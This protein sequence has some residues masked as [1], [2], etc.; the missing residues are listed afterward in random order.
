MSQRSEP[1]SILLEIVLPE[2][3]QTAYLLDPFIPVLRGFGETFRVT[4]LRPISEPHTV[5]STES[6]II[7]K[8][9]RPVKRQRLDNPLSASGYSCQPA[10]SGKTTHCLPLNGI[11]LEAA[12][13]AAIKD[14]IQQ[15]IHLVRSE[16]IEKCHATRHSEW[17]SDP[18]TLRHSALAQLEWLSYPESKNLMPWFDWAGMTRDSLEVR[19]SKFNSKKLS[20][21]VSEF[22][23]TCLNPS[24]NSVGQVT[25]TDNKF[26]VTLPRRSGFSLATMENFRN[27]V[28]RINHSSG[29]DAVVIDPPWQNKSASRGG[30]YRTVELYDLFKMDL[31]GILGENAGK[32]ALIAIWVTNRPKFRRFL[33]NKFLPD[34]HVMGPYSEWYWVKITASPSKENQPDLLEGGKPIFDLESTSPRRCYEG[35]VLGWYIPPSLRLNPVSN[36]IPSKIFLSVPLC[37][38]RKPNIIDLLAPHIPSDPSILELFSRSVSG[39]PSFGEN[40]ENKTVD[41]MKGIWH[42]VGDECP[43]FMVTPWVDWHKSDKQDSGAG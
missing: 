17:W 13:H 18:H 26:A 31:P 4:V 35:L 38:S 37:H 21:R 1:S 42:S 25:L 16:W 43:K 36:E 23:T 15:A 8:G 32:R 10:M 14:D 30:K 12:H 22:G 19:K 33:K 20:I 27:E 2:K 24:S 3:N 40:S 34:C 6:Q 9:I 39:L 5:P 28:T 41:P 29:W 11:Q 7:C